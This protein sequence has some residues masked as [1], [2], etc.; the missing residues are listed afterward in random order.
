[1]PDNSSVRTRAPARDRPHLSAGFLCSCLLA[2]SCYVCVFVLLYFVVYFLFVFCICVFFVRICM[3]FSVR[4]P[5]VADEGRDLALLVVALSVGSFRGLTLAS[6]FMYIYIYIYTH[7][8]MY[9][10]ILHV[11]IMCIY[12]YI[13]I[14]TCRSLVCCVLLFVLWL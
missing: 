13:Y 3:F 1:M 9:T 2:F 4:A 7:T 8:Y 5:D 6:L 10:Y 11:Y 14:Y 12:I